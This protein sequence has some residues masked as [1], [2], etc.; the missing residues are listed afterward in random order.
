M[1]YSDNPVRDAEMYMARQEAE[2]LKMPI[3]EHCGERIQ[4]DYY[5]IDGCIVCDDC[6]LEYLR[7]NCRVSA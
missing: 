1:F 7:K 2:L 3:C 6:I 4:D 5:E